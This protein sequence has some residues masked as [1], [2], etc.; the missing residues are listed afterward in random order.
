MFTVVLGTYLG[1]GIAAL[2]PEQ[3]WKY[4]GTLECSYLF[5]VDPGPGD[6]SPFASPLLTDRH[7][8]VLCYRSHCIPHRYVTLLSPISRDWRP[9]QAANMA[10]PEAK[11]PW[12][13]MGIGPAV[14]MGS[15]A[16]AM[17]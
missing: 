7:Q 12:G 3:I 6:E 16:I 9:P 13:P 17:A 2:L 1:F 10:H 14:K 15:L 8:K 4:L 5:H 11:V